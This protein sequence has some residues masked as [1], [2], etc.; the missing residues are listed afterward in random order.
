MSSMLAKVQ[1]VEHKRKI[2]FFK[3]FLT[4]ISNGNLDCFRLNIL[5]PSTT[6][7]KEFQSS[8]DKT[9]FDIAVFK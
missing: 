9:V 7:I 4:H 8:S 2:I 1:Q 3:V 6:Q 5:S